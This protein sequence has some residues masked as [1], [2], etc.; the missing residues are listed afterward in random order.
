[1]RR[2][3]GF[4]MCALA[5]VVGCRGKFADDE[6]RAEASRSTLRRLSDDEL[7]RS[8]VRTA[9]RI[10]DDHADDPIGTEIPFSHR[11]RRYVA[12]LETHY[13]PVGGAERPRGAHRGVTLLAV[14]AKPQR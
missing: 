4:T 2:A 13:H 3:L 8:L 10:L 5:S 6:A 14:E 12:R 7:T 1:M 11:G 9:E